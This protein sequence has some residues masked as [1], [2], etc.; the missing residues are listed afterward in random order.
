MS[1]EFWRNNPKLLAYLL[2]QQSSVTPGLDIG[3]GEPVYRLNSQMQAVPD[4]QAAGLGVPIL[5]T[6]PR[7]GS[8]RPAISY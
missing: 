5:Y 8:M 6:D 7:A 3:R 1:P 4:W 2:G